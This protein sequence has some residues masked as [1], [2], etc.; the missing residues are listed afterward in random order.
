M[1]V[2]GSV[3][4]GDEDSYVVE[5]SFYGADGKLALTQAAVAGSGG[6]WRVGRAV[7]ELVSNVKAG[8]P[9]AGVVTGVGADGVQVNLGRDLFSIGGN[10]V[11]MLESVKRN[12]EGRIVGDSDG[13]TLKVRRTRDAN[14]LLQ[15]EA[16]RGA[17]PPAT[18]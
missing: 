6:S 3:S 2:F 16:L 12:G 10:D 8:Y 1:V 5:V 17:P 15:A 4:R 18:A 13:G 14:S 7:D 9:I 11:F